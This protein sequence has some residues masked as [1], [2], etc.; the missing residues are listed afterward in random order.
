MKFISVFIVNKRESFENTKMFVIVVLLQQRLAI[1]QNISHE[2]GNVFGNKSVIEYIETSTET[3]EGIDGTATML[4]RTI[5]WKDILK[6]TQQ[7]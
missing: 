6:E 4:M 3:S 7:W 1:W 2:E 5:L